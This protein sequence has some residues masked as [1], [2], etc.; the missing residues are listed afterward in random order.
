M[1]AP[2]F[3]VYAKDRDT[4]RIVE[5]SNGRW[6]AAM[7]VWPGKY[8]GKDDVQIDWSHPVWRNP[9][10]ADGKPQMFLEMYPPRAPKGGAA[11]K[12][13]DTERDSEAATPARDPFEQ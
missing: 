5:D 12:T 10:T 11:P 8:P 1:P 6:W 3:K 2:K 13:D 4:K 9:R 7:T